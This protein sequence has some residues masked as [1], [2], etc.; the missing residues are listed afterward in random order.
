[1]QVIPS[2]GFSSLNEHLFF[3]LIPLLLSSIPC[4]DII[5]CSPQTKLLFSNV[6]W[7]ELIA[8]ALT[9]LEPDEMSC[10]NTQQWCSSGTYPLAS[11]PRLVR[12]V[13]KSS[14]ISH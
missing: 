1:M 5:K 7:T 3:Y 6:T 10:I 11:E 9:Q 13:I 14:F 2:R 4:S 12:F 8:Q